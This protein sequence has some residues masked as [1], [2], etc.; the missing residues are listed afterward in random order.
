MIA[1]FWPALGLTFFAGMSTAVGSLIAFFL[2]GGD[3]R[4]LAIAL[5]F[6]AGVMIFISL[7]ELLPQGQAALSTQLGTQAGGSWAMA[8]FVIGMLLMGAIDRLIPTTHNPHEIRDFQHE[9]LNADEQA[10]LL[11]MGIFMGMA[12]FIHNFPEG[13]STFVTALQDPALGFSIAIAIALHNIPEGISVSVPIYYATGSR[14]KAMLYSSL[15]G[16][17]EPV[18]ALAAYG[19][20]VAHMSEFY[21]G[22]L[23]AIVAGMMIYISFDEL[24]PSAQEYGEHHLSLY[25]LLGGMI[26]M[27]L[28]LLFFR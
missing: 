21:F 2:K 8:C 17:S 11:R 5:G 20:L 7:T 12:I 10:R 4:I 15:T 18:G 25:G 13:I 6:S 19:L 1:N 9:N 26:L 3:R 23:L 16:F 22:G 27:G 28:S 14:G 24:L